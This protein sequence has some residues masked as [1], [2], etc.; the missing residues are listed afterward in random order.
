MSRLSCLALLLL[1][2]SCYEP[3][4]DV[5]CFSDGALLSGS[6]RT[7]DVCCD[8][9]AADGDRATCAGYFS[10]N[11][12]SPDI[13]LTAQCVAP[14][15]CVL[16]CP[17]GACECVVDLD[18]RD[19]ALP[20]CAVLSAADRCEESGL[21]AIDGRCTACAVCAQDTDCETGSC[22]DGACR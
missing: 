22:V 11:G 6:A 15:A 17:D 19:P 16:P 21:A 3:I 14:G 9:T 7:T 5:H 20:H 10:D 2:S 18:C 8:V 1:L 4:E 12:Y 13:S